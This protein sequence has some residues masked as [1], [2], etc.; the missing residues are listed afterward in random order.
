VSPYFQQLYPFS[1]WPTSDIVESAAGKAK[2]RPKTNLEDLLSDPM[3]YLQAPSRH[4]PGSTS[5]KVLPGLFE[6]QI[7]RGSV[8]DVT[9]ATQCSDDKL[10]EIIS[11]ANTTDIPISVAVL[12]LKSVGLTIELI[13]RLRSCF[14]CVARFVDFHVALVDSKAD[15]YGDFKHE[16]DFLMRKLGDV[17]APS[18]GRLDKFPCNRL[19]RDGLG[20]IFGDGSNYI[21]KGVPYPTTL[22]RNTALEWVK[23]KHVITLDADLVPSEGFGAAYIRAFNE[24]QSQGRNTSHFVIVAPGMKHS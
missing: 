20:V 18:R 1:K 7:N 23:S 13:W 9:I 10:H 4:I 19:H 6:G 14:E 22:L 16:P 5:F 17:I 11:M 24:L 3:W 15:L 8:P 2:E 12:A 21:N